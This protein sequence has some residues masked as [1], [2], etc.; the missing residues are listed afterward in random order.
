LVPFEGITKVNLRIVVLI[1][2]Y[3]DA[4]GPGGFGEWNRCTRVQ[5]MILVHF[6]YFS[7]EFGCD[8]WSRIEKS[9]EMGGCG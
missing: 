4:G 6:A 5:G 8:L 9:E 1:G 7:I 3:G 2:G